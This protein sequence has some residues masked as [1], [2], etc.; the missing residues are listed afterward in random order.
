[1]PS[2]SAAHRQLKVNR[3]YGRVTQALLSLYP[4]PQLYDTWA[5]CSPLKYLCANEGGGRGN[6]E[7][8]YRAKLLIA[9]ETAETASESEAIESN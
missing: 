3:A 2:D 4:S 1:M 6:S 7:V 9:A 5:L 8:T